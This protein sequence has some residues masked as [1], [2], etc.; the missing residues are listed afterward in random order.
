MPLY[1]WIRTSDKQCRITVVEV[2]S[3]ESEF[4][5]NYNVNENTSLGGAGLSLEKK[6]ESDDKLLLTGTANKSINNKPKS[7]VLNTA[8]KVNHL[9]YHSHHIKL[10]DQSEA[11]VPNFIGGSLPRRDSG[12][13]EQYCQ[14]LCPTK[15]VLWDNV[16]NSHKFTDR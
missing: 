4:E 14:D 15:D 3:G 10:L 8:C 2:N 6:E 12:N 16:F 13:H 11:F 9:Q 1:D 7:A 5:K